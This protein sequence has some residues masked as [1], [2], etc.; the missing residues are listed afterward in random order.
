MRSRWS[1]TDLQA[2]Q[3]FPHDRIF[4]LVRP[5]APD[6][7]HSSDSGRKKGLFVML[8]LEEAL[9]RVQ[10]TLDV[11]TLRLD[12]HAGRTPAALQAELDDEA[13]RAKVE[14]VDLATCAD[15][16]QRAAPGS[17]APAA[18]SWT[19]RTT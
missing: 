8:M 6:R 17:F 10:T 13:A 14:E 5:G 7:H 9:A 12:D 11:E 1:R 18:I 19:S 3:P 15:A 16:S 2:G 4:A